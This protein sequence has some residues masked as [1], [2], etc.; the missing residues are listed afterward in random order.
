MARNVEIKARIADLAAIRARVALLSTQPSELVNQTDTF[1]AVPKG[2]L[3][4]RAFQDGS[5]ELIS[6]ERANNAGPKESVYT[7]VACRDAWS[8]AQALQRVLSVRGVVAKQ[9]EVFLV[10]RTRVHL[11]RVE[12]LGCFVELEVV[13]APAEPV[14]DGDREARELLRLLEIPD[15]ALLAEAYID[16]LEIGDR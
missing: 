12:R 14:E 4:V 9:R 7:R 8:L 6:Y 16:L 10:G 2:R 11:D 13:L 5:G 1:F 3:K 15:H